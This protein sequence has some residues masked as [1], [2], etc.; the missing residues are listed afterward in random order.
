MKSFNKDHNHVMASPMSMSYT[1]CL[2]KMNVLLKSCEKKIKE[3]GLPTGKAVVIFNND[4]S[5]LSN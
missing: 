5:S 2:K 1:R 3:E 4:D